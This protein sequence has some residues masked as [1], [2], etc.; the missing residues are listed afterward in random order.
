MAGWVQD[1]RSKRVNSKTTDQSVHLKPES[2][3]YRILKGQKVKNKCVEINKFGYTQGSATRGSGAACGSPVALC[4][5][6]SGAYFSRTVNLTNQFHMINVKV[7]MNV[8]ESHVHFLNHRIRPSW[9]TRSG[10]VCVCV[11]VLPDSAHTHTGPGIPTPPHSLGNTQWDRSS[12]EGAV[13][14][15]LKVKISYPLHNMYN[16]LP[17]KQG[18]AC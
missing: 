17:H 3:V 1:K 18:L 5:L 12:E 8:S 4:S 14:T 6:Q 16:T 15:L 11:C 10:L 13:I 2:S 9:N 7:T